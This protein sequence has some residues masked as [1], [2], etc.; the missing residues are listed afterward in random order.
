MIMRGGRSPLGF[1]LRSPLGVR[2]CCCDEVEVKTIIGVSCTDIGVE[3]IISGVNH[4]TEHVSFE[5]NCADIWK[6]YIIDHSCYNGT[7]DSFNYLGTSCP[8]YFTG[9]VWYKSTN[10][11]TCAVECLVG[12]CPSAQSSTFNV[13]VCDRESTGERYWKVS[14]GDAIATKITPTQV[15]STTIDFVKADDSVCT[16]SGVYSKIITGNPGSVTIN[17]TI[18]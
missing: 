3:A 16:G 13:T 10:P 6:H 14:I 12:D 11:T 4:F 7:W 8:A 17:L 9:C 18:P 1:K 5:A 2:G 15:I